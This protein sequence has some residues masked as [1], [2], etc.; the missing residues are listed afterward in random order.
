MAQRSPKTISVPIHGGRHGSS[1]IAVTIPDHFNVERYVGWSCI[2]NCSMLSSLPF[3]YAFCWFAIPT[4]RN[5]FNVFY[6]SFFLAA[7]TCLSWSLPSITEQQV[8]PHR[9]P[10][11]CW[12]K[13]NSTDQ[14]LFKHCQHTNC[15]P[16]SAILRNNYISLLSDLCACVHVKIKWHR[17]GSHSSSL[18]GSNRLVR[19]E[20]WK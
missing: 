19:L 2:L 4:S 20:T 3:F 7:D 17:K 8:C 16:N 5:I 11:Q 12:L 15:I 13:N 14:A 18:S 6:S 9:L 1:T 10:M